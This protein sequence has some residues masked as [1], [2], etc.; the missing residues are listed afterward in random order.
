MDNLLSLFKSTYFSQWSAFPC[1][2]T[3]HNADVFRPLS[4]QITFLWVD[5]SLF[6]LSCCSVTVVP[7]FSPL[8]SSTNPP[9]APTVS[10]LPLSVPVSPLFMFL[11]LLLPLLTPVIPVPWSLSVLY[12]HVSG[13]I[14][15]VCLFCWLDST[16]RWDHMV[17]VFYCPVYYT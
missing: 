16:Y 9:P 1:F 15:L 8:L 17:F 12:F 14:L 10:P 6:V 2:I 3:D 5:S 11:N 4:N 7:P 13:S